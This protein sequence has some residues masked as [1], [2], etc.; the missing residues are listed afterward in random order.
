MTSNLRIEFVGLSSAIAPSAV[1]D[2][3]GLAHDS[4]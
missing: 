3:P 2:A 1:P 4:S